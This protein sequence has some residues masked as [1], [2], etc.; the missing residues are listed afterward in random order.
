[1]SE[2]HEEDPWFLRPEW[3]ML[4]AFLMGIVIAVVGR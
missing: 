3:L 4:V 2:H 1:M